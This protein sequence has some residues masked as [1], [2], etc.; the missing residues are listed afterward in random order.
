MMSS[1]WLLLGMKAQCKVTNTVATGINGSVKPAIQPDGVETQQPASAGCPIR[2]T[3]LEN[4]Q[5]FTADLKWKSSTV[6]Y[7]MPSP[8]R[9]L[10]D[11]MILELGTL[12]C[13]ASSFTWTPFSCAMTPG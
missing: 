13:W 4:N 9:D 6:A 7:T 5:P 1:L 3:I 11:S 12:S 8:S 2:S 10:I